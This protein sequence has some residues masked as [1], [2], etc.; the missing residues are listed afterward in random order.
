MGFPRRS[1][2]Y[3][4]ITAGADVIEFRA[5]IPLERVNT[6]TTRVRK[7]GYRNELSDLCMYT[8]TR[9]IVYCAKS[10]AERIK[11]CTFHYANRLHAGPSIQ[12]PVIDLAYDPA[13]QL[14]SSRAEISFTQ[15]RLLLLLIART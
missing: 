13:S 4:E 9:M 3:F 6:R 1:L 10:L 14:A 15:S 2:N 11:R 7:W 12:S 8:C 5:L